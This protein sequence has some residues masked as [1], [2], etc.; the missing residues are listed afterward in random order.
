MSVAQSIGAVGSYAAGPE[1]EPRL[2]HASAPAFF[3]LFFVIRL[4]RI[5]SF[6]LSFFFFSFFYPLPLFLSTQNSSSCDNVTYLSRNNSSTV[7]KGLHVFEI[8][9]SNIDYIILVSVLLSEGV[10]GVDGVGVMRAFLCL[11][12]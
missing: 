10:C 11:T 2:R 1:F 3:L 5:F 12:L 4:R 9:G 7:P 6:F 8:Q